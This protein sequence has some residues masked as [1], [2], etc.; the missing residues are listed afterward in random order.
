MTT[1]ITGANR[2]IGLG[3]HRAYAAR[4]EEVRS[5][6]HRRPARRAGRPAA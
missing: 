2:G 3:L 1:L 5:G 6:H 4:G